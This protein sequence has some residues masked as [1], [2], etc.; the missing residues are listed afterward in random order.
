MKVVTYRG[1]HIVLVKGIQDGRG[2]NIR[3]IIE[4]QSQLPIDRA[5]INAI[6]A[7]WDRT[8]LGAHNI[9]S[10]RPRRDLERIASRTIVELGIRGGTV[11]RT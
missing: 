4:S 2:V 8:N 6:P 7:V 10:N 1:S 3:P 11:S 5:L 9:G